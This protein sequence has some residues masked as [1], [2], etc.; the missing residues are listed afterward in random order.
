M[1]QA[2]PERHSLKRNLSAMAEN[3]M[4]LNAHNEHTKP[5]PHKETYEKE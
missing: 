3:K 2:Q 4:R 1:K 5:L